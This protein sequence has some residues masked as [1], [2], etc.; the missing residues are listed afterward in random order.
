MP[1]VARRKFHHR[2]TGG[3]SAV[4]LSDRSTAR[5]L[6][7][8]GFDPSEGCLVGFSPRLDGA[9]RINQQLSAH[10]LYVV[11]FRGLSPV[12]GPPSAAAAGQLAG[13]QRRIG[14]DWTA[15]S[16]RLW[17]GDTLN[18]RVEACENKADP[19]D[20]FTDPLNK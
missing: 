20:R 9:N 7:W 15:Q 5:A 19:G 17:F 3:N 10:R 2:I 6:S 14:P 13:S 12:R 4:E 16:S 1:A 11:R 8:G 18:E